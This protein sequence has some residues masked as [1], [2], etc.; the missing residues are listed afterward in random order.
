M[1]SCVMM[2][3]A[4]SPLTASAEG[5][6]A[7]DPVNDLAGDAAQE[8]TWSDAYDYESGAVITQD[9]FIYEVTNTGQESLTI[10]THVYES[11]GDEA[12]LASDTQ[13]INTDETASLIA[14]KLGIGSC[15]FEFGS[16]TFDE[17]GNTLTYVLY[18]YGLNEEQNAELDAAFAE[19]LAMIGDGFDVGIVM[20]DDWEIEHYD[21]TDASHYIFDDS[22]ML[23]KEFDVPQFVNTG[24]ISASLG[25]DLYVDAEMKE[26]VIAAYVDA[27]AEKTGYFK[28]PA[29]S[30]EPYDDRE[31]LDGNDGGSDIIPDG[32]YYLRPW[33]SYTYA[34]EKGDIQGLYYSDELCEVTLSNVTDISK[35]H[36]MVQQVIKNDEKGSFSFFYGDLSWINILVT[37]GFD[38]HTPKLNN[39]KA[40]LQTQTGNN[41]KTLVDELDKKDWF[42]ILLHYGGSGDGNTFMNYTN[43][44]PY[45]YI[46]GEHTLFYRGFDDAEKN[47]IYMGSVLYVSNQ[48]RNDRAEAAEE[49][50]NDYLGSGAFE[51]NVE[52]LTSQAEKVELMRDAGYDVPDGAA[53]VYLTEYG[54]AFYDSAAGTD[55]NSF[56]GLIPAMECEYWDDM[57]ASDEKLETA[58]EN[59]KVVLEDY[60]DGD[61]PKQT[62]ETATG[63][64]IYRL[65]LT[66]NDN[67]QSH[68]YAVAVCR[69]N[70]EVKKPYANWQ[71]DGT[72]ITTKGVNGQVPFDTYTEID[73]VRDLSAVYDAAK[74][75][76]IDTH[77]YDINA[78][79]NYTGQMTDELGTKDGK[80][81][82]MFP[83]PADYDSDNVKAYWY[84]EENEEIVPY[85][86]T[87]EQGDDGTQYVCIETDHFSQYGISNGD[88][89]TAAGEGTDEPDT[90]DPVDSAQG[91]ASAEADD[92]SAGDG[93]ETGDDNNA[94]ILAAI[95]ALAAA[96]AAGTVL[97]GKKKRRNS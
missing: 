55:K 3:A 76:D 42:D 88:L 19:P 90:D 46:N 41:Y 57:F 49:R 9:E 66:D 54:F 67:G 38:A 52:K 68:D 7:S 13:T 61:P 77:L 60:S 22:M 2:I 23:V 62:V 95:M 29:D 74:N 83:L 15:L 20:P 87:V 32:T 34:A 24:N 97:Y 51:A 11:E 73:E 50:I 21:R 58:A 94:A 72:G 25:Y 93:A 92:K 47:G 8:A 70:Q 14:N 86:H 63:Y 39:E 33:Y 75:S 48:D 26:K 43:A 16:R 31:P 82:I 40:F 59:V 30:E 53:A 27:D 44:R 78:Y 37:T 69:D 12:P 71:D 1:I 45:Y 10:S 36:Q 79:S 18:R 17:T 89:L 64:E 80:M 96:A 91:G 84:D 81:E 5:D 56:A 28:V 35:E 4:M 65:T 85:K 6:P